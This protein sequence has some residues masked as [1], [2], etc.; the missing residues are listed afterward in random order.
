MPWKMILV[1]S[2]GATAVLATAPAKAP[3]KSELITDR[4]LFRPCR[5]SDGGIT[6]RVTNTKHSESRKNCISCQNKVV[7][8]MLLIIKPELYKR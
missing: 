5:E 1:L 6:F 3:E 7:F 4:V 8:E 2:S